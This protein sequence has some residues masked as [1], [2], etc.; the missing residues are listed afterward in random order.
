MGRFQAG[1]AFVLAAACSVST[2]RAEAPP[3]SDP[4][5]RLIEGF[6]A[7]GTFPTTVTAA[8]VNIRPQSG[9]EF[10]G[11]GEDDLRVE[12][13][14]AGPLNWTSSRYN[15]GDIALSI[16]PAFPENPLSYPEPA[17]VT[18]FQAMNGNSDPINP[19]SRDLTTLAWR[20]NSVTGALFASTRHNGVDDGY[21]SGGTPIGEIF[22]VSYFASGG[23]QGWAFQM[24]NGE[25][26]NSGPG[27][28]DLTLGQAGN[29]FG[30]TEASF[31]A[32]VVYLPYEQGWQ[33]AWVNGAIDGEA[34]FAS[35]APDLQPSSVQWASGVA[36]I[37]LPGVNSAADGMLFVAP[38][39]GDSNTRIAA[40]FPTGGGWAAAVRLDED[41]DATGFSL[42]FGDG[43]QFLYVPYTATN[44]I[45]G[46]I[47]GTSGSSITSAGDARFDVTRNSA[48]QYAVS[49]YEAD[50]T[51]KKTEDD[52]MLML[53][54]A[55]SMPGADDLPDRT[56]LSYEFDA[57]SGNFIVQS[58]E[59]LSIFGSDDLFGN[60]F[61]LRDS[62]FYFAWVDFENPLS[63][64]GAAVPGDFDGD[65]DVDG[66]DLTVWR[67]AYGPGAAGDADGDGDTDGNDFLVW[68]QNVGAGLPAAGAAGA[69][70]EPATLAMT[71]LAGAACLG[72]ARRRR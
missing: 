28:S 12:F 25:F 44:L 17:F 32:A 33:G 21:V 26:A 37:T 59:L 10:D 39:S 55:S 61:E 58:R 70:P 52:G 15:S 34:T 50:G 47:Q 31:N 72:A 45:G 23:G 1:L 9:A 14:A 49:I 7:P 60:D 53:S 54:V 20:T 4:S 6:N 57:G 71:L 68:Q 35:G 5:A 38:S 16:G 46:H 69:V 66:A 2:V 22:G 63:L 41:T 8:N 65:G 48:G 3:I 29:A 27:S 13:P 36:T 67:G 43:F 30:L 18:N 24:A 64:G 56:F 11:P 40:A 19:D 62:N 51:T 42:Q